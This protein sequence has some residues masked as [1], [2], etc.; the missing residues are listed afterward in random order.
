MLGLKQSM[1]HRCRVTE[2]WVD[3]CFATPTFVMERCG[4][5]FET[6]AHRGKGGGGWPNLWRAKK[7]RK[8]MSTSD[9]AIRKGKGMGGNWSEKRQSQVGLE[10]MLSP[11]FDKGVRSLPEWPRTNCVGRYLAICFSNPRPQILPLFPPP[12][13]RLLQNCTPPHFLI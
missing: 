6:A 4:G 7:F 2:T 3:L 11:L 8:L 13:T 10:P 9:C 12:V 1:K 5:E